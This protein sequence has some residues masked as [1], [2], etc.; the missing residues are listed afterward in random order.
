MALT[1]Y[2][3]TIWR[4]LLVPGEVELSKVHGMFQAAM[5]WEDRHLHRFEIGDHAYV[6]DDIE[7]DGDEIDED[8]VLLAEVI[9]QP[10]RFAYL[11]DFG[12]GW[13]HEVVVE[14]IQPLP[15]ALKFAVCLDGQRACPPEDCGGVG[16]FTE[17]LQAMSDPGHRDHD[18]YAGWIGRPFDPEEFSVAATNARLQRVR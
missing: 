11:Y 18:H 16:G 14:S 13:A 10:M 17:F 5:G 15:T 4:R 3:P 12:D 6:A 2:V 1:R 7:L 8:S 9:E